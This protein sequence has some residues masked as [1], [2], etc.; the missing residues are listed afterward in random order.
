MFPKFISLSYIEKC[1]VKCLSHVYVQE[2]IVFSDLFSVLAAFV[3]TICV[4]LWMS[5]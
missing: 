4:C 2:L 1:I 3:A 5:L